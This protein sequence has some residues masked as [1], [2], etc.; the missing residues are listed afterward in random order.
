MD[1]ALVA[2]WI[3]GVMNDWADAASRM[4]V[5][6]EKFERFNFDPAKR[7]RVDVPELLN[8]CPPGGRVSFDK[9]ARPLCAPRND[10]IETGGLEGKLRGRQTDG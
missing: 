1:I 9:L 8:R 6:R 5:D 3:P 2:R 10:V 4:E 7:L